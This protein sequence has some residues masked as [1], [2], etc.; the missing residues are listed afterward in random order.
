[1]RLGMD[2][3]KSKKQDLLN[4]LQEQKKEE[5]Y[6]AKLDF[7]TNITHEFCTPLTLINGVCERILSYGKSDKYVQKYTNVL[8]NNAK[9]LNELIQEIIDF[10]KFGE[11]GFDACH[12]EKSLYLRIT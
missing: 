4:K 5:L 11:V 8:Y 2:K 10:R 12:I 9:H 3:M 6:N 1:M 7:F